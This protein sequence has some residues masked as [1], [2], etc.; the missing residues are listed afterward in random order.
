MFEKQGEGESGFSVLALCH[1]KMIA[2]YDPNTPVS[3]INWEFLTIV[4]AYF[5]TQT[6]CKPF[7]KPFFFNLLP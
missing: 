5:A 7:H 6:L 3:N 1:K 4:A 2:S